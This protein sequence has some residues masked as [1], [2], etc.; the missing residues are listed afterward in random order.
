MFTL[1]GT[2][3]IM[4]SC[5]S[6]SNVSFAPSKL[7]VGQDAAS[8]PTATPS[9][10]AQPFQA[11]GPF[12]L[13][14]S[15]GFN[16][17]VAPAGNADL[18]TWFDLNGLC[19][20]SVNAIRIDRLAAT[21]DSPG[22]F[23]YQSNNVYLCQQHGDRYEMTQYNGRHLGLFHLYHG[24]SGS[25]DLAITGLSCPNGNLNS[26]CVAIQSEAYIGHLGWTSGAFYS[27]LELVNQNNSS[28]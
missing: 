28:D 17:A 22:L 15:F 18:Y 2:A 4:S 14:Q 7:Q 3:F 13:V 11:D 10:A 8:I 6:V 19:N 1:L 5:G 27:N 21:Q 16:F 26:N 25:F 24:D 23:F 12:A 9:N 20:S